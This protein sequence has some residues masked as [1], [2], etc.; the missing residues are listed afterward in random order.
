MHDDD[1][2]IDGSTILTAS[3]L[4][5]D[6]LGLRPEDVRIE[7]VAHHLSNQCRYSGA[8]SRFYSVA[9]HS[10]RAAYYVHTLGRNGRTREGQAVVERWALLHDAAEAY[11]Q[12]MVRPLKDDPELGAAYRE[13]EERA[14]RVVAERFGLPWPMPDVVRQADLALLALERREL[15]PPN[16]RW[17]ILDGVEPAAL[18]WDDDDRHAELGWTPDEARVAVLTW[19]AVL[20]LA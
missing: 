5:V 8:T 14:M 12:D 15:M 7:D 6:P 16:G 3:G 20:G 13:A 2:R 4:Y 19:A 1:V 18:G 17:A 9:E 11:L 10:C